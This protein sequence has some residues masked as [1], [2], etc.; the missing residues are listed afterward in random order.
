MIAFWEHGSNQSPVGLVRAAADWLKSARETVLLSK[1]S[2]MD[3]IETRSDI[4]TRFIPATPAEVFAVIRDPVRVARWWGPSGFTNTIHTYEFVP[5]G[6]WLLTMH[7]PDGKDYPNESRFTRIVPD[8]LFEIEH[9]NG[10]RFVLTIE[11]EP[12]AEG[13]RVGWRQTFD[14][15]E[16]YQQ[17][18]E[19]VAMANQQNLERMAAE[20][21][22]P[23]SAA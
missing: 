5:G 9:L 19:F 12:H 21:A 1:E 20:V 22:G 13:T 18:A 17:L 7:G 3:A 4:R 15:V 16:H 2:F 8:E 6:S 14:T 23:G 11:L 10:H